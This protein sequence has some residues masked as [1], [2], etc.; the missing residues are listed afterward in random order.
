M[1]VS[2]VG[3]GAVPWYAVGNVLLAASARVGSAHITRGGAVGA[4]SQAPV[5]QRRQRRR[6]RASSRASGVSRAAVS[7]PPTGT[8]PPGTPSSAPAYPCPL[9]RL[10]SPM[11]ALGDH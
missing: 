5:V 6:R 7:D 10:A 8:L 1:P 3:G 4:R 11:S 2:C 9:S